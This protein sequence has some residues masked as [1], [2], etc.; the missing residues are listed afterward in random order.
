MN[1]ET[2]NNNVGT[3]NTNVVQPTPVQNQEAAP[4]EMPVLN[5]ENS[6]A[7][8]AVEAPTTETVPTE[9]QVAPTTEAVATEPPTEQNNKKIEAPT[10]VVMPHNPKVNDQVLV[11]MKPEK[12]GNLIGV[13]L[14]FGLIGAFLFFLPNIGQFIGTI[15][16]SLAQGEPI[17]II[18]KNNENQEETKKEEK[19]P[20]KEEKKELYDIDSLV[21]NAAMDNIKLGNFVKDQK[22]GKYIMKFYLLNDGE[23]AF[24]FDD[25]SK[26]FID[27]YENDKYISS[28][29]IYTFD[30]I[31]SKESKDYEVVIPKRVYDKANKF[32][33]SRK[34]TAE[35]PNITLKKTDGDY[36]ILTC[37]YDY[38][39][40]EYFFIDNYLERIEETYKVDNNV[41]AY[42]TLLQEKQSLSNVYKDI[43]AIEHDVIESSTNF[44]AKTTISL[45]DIDDSTLNRLS[46]Y[47]FFAYHKESKVVSYELQSLGYTCS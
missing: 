23:T 6:T 10:E 1:G 29:I 14:F 7:P 25:K 44:V 42:T 27:F 12:D 5:T 30:V 41:P 28:V 17:Y 31:A 40:V 2:N 36:K 39:K 46:T 38:D 22:E 18:P 20:D 43:P 13:I 4:V 24:S 11:E 34:K 21:S 37:T 32:M 26:F 47:K 8:V 16:P 3:E 45:K 9:G 19:D 35:Y 33:L 15:F